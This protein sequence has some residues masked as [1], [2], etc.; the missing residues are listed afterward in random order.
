MVKKYA[1]IK[2][3]HLGQVHLPLSAAQFGDKNCSDLRERFQ[4]SFYI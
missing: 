2:D 4:V 1:Y 3:E